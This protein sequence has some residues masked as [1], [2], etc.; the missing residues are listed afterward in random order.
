MTTPELIENFYE[1]F[2][3]KYPH[4]SLNEIKLIVNAPFQMFK[5]TMQSGEFEDV[6]LQYLFVARVSAPRVIRHLTS[7][8][9]NKKEGK[10]SEKAF[11]KYNGIFLRYIDKNPSRFKKYKDRINQITDES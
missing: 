8:Y 3:E 9:R 2:K 7:I 1:N 5:E 10:I 11:D 4:L 6:R